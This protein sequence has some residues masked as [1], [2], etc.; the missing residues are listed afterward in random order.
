MECGRGVESAGL[1]EKMAMPTV[2]QQ[3]SSL[4]WNFFVKD[5]LWDPKTKGI[6]A[7]IC[8]LCVP[9]K[10]MKQK[11]GVTSNMTKHLQ[12]QHPK[13]YYDGAVNNKRQRADVND[14]DDDDD[15]CSGSTSML[16]VTKK[17]SQK[18]TSF[19]SSSSGNNSDSVSSSKSASSSMSA[20]DSFTTN[21]SSDENKGK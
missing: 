7:V 5:G 15:I 20:I 17:T 11:G 3:G 6:D 12:T 16:R 10:R 2:V 1:N 19:V 21:S 13:E 18:L 9:N 8:Q 14:G 4:V